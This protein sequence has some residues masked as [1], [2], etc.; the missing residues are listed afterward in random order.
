MKMF[1]YGINDFLKSKILNNPVK[2]LIECFI[3]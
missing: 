3:K 1:E 2:N